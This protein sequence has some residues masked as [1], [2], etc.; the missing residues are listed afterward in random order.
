MKVLWCPWCKAIKE[1]E[2]KWHNGPAQIP[3]N[4]LD[5][6]CPMCEYKLVKSEGIE[7]EYYEEETND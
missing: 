4:A 3:D 5:A 2:G 6:I 7:K 1:N